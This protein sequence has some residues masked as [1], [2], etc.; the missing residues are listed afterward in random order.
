MQEIT[1]D[2]FGH[3][4]AG[5]TAI[6]ILTNGYV[7]AQGANT[8]GRGC[9]AEAKYRWPGIQLSIGAAIRHGGNTCHRLTDVI[10]GKTLL[11][12]PKPWG[13]RYQ[14]PYHL[15]SF[16]TKQHWRE[17]SDLDLIESS[18]QQLLVLTDRMDLQS[19]VMPRPGCGMGRLSWE[20]EVRPLLSPIL[21]DRFY[22]I[23]FAR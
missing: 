9:A 6:C 5:P 11:G 8:M 2:L 19:V 18:A 17:K 3:N 14:L 10:D 12:V 4:Q 1:G 15:F 13:S 21:D 16:P 7:N 22:A 20:D 23:T